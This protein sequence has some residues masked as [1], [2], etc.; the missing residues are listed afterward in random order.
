[1]RETT[2]KRHRIVRNE[3]KKLAGSMPAMLLYARLAQQFGY[4]ESHIRRIL[5]KNNPL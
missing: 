1:M 3:F 2:K 4:D 5:Q